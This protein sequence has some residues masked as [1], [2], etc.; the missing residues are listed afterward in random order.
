MNNLSEEDLTKAIQEWSA[1]TGKSPKDLLPSLEG[2]AEEIHAAIRKCWFKSH[3]IFE[4]FFPE[5]IFFLSQ[6]G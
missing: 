3:S 5:T 2:D 4:T 6:I 1:R